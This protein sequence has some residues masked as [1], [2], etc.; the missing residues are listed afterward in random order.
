MKVLITGASSLPGFRVALE[1]LKRDFQVIG[2][3]LKNPIPLKNER[4]FTQFQIDIQNTK[5]LRGLIE[6][7]KPQITIHMAALGDVDYCERKKEEAWKT[8]VLSS[9]DLFRYASKVSELLVYLSTDYV[10]DGKKGDYREDDAPSP[11]NYYG[12]TKLCG[13]LVCRTASINSAIIRASSIYGFGPGRKN[14]AKFLVEKLQEKET[15]GALV[16]QFTTPTQASLLAEAM[17]EIIE[18]RLTGI[19]HIV[20][21]K[22][23]RFEFAVKVADALGFD[24][25]L[26]RDTKMESMKWFAKR[27]VDSS[28]NSEQTHKRLKTDFYS[29]KKAFSVL[30][31]E[32]REL[33]V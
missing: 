4:K 24:S 13:E 23:N 33:R 30:K 10:F 22:M 28:L 11:V 25:K 17:V 20:G 3:Y 16:D 5:S 2:T 14:F 18:K 6:K 29:S 1:L 12:F 27:P 15:V 8:N 32:F 19:F 9:I 26:I 31:E 21:E 7:T